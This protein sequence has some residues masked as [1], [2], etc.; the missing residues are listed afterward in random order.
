M[1]AHRNP[2]RPSILKRSSFRGRMENPSF[3]SRAR[4]PAASLDRV[5]R[6]IHFNSLDILAGSQI[7][8]MILASASRRRGVGRCKLCFLS[9]GRLHDAGFSLVLVLSGGIQLKML[10]LKP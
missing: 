3:Q 2:I 1:I 5:D 9:P 10:L 4:N 8:S 7:P 6:I